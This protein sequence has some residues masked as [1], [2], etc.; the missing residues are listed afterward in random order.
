MVAWAVWDCNREL[1]S[2]LTQLFGICHFFPFFDY[3][4]IDLSI[5]VLVLESRSPKTEGTQVWH[6]HR[7][8]RAAISL[9]T[10]L[11]LR[12]RTIHF[13]VMVGLPPTAIIMKLSGKIRNGNI[14]IMLNDAIE[15]VTRR[16]FLFTH[17][18]CCPSVRSSVCRQNPYTQMSF[19]Q[20]EA[21]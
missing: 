15:Y 20:K 18:C 13:I 10:P 2:L 9:A 14:G 1:V 8:H 4:F 16:G 21:T 3:I 12:C 11:S 7:R 6:P 17:R 19:S 5:K